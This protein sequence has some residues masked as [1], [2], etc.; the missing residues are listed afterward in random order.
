[1]PDH[2]RVSGGLIDMAKHMGNLQYRVW[3]KMQGKNSIQ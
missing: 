1:L 3:E 2:E